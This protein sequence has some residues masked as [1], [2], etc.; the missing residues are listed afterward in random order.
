M[1]LDKSFSIGCFR[2][3]GLLATLLLLTAPLAHGQ[4]TDVAAE[5]SLVALWELNEAAGSG[6]VLDIN[7]TYTGTVSGGTTL[8]VPSAMTTLGTAAHF[9][10]SNGKIDIPYAA[11]LNPT[12]YTVEAWAQ[13]QGGAGSYRSP[14]T[15]RRSGPQ[16]QG[17][18]L[19]AASN[20]NWEYW[21]GTGTG[22]SSTPSGAPVITNQWV[23]LAATY[24]DGSG[25]KILYLNGHPV[26]TATA[27]LTP[28]TGLPTRIGAGG[29][30][31]S[32]AYWFNGTVDNVAILNQAM[33]HQNVANHYNAKSLYANQVAADGPAAYWRLGEQAGSSAYNAIDVTAHTG[34]YSNVAL[35]QTD[36]PIGN[37]I[38]TAASFAHG[39]ARVSVPYSAEL[40]P[41]GSFTV[42]AW[43]RADGGE[44]SY[45]SVLTSRS[46]AGNSQGFILYANNNNQWSFWNGAGTSADWH[47]IDGPQVALGEWVHLVGTYDAGT[48]VKSFYVDGVLAGSTSGVNYVA[49]TTNPLFIGM[50]GNGGT[51]FPFNGLIDEVAM[52]GQALTSAA[53]Q[54]HYLLASTGAE[55][56]RWDGGGTGMLWSTQDNWDPAGSP[57]DK[58]VVFDNTAAS[59]T[60]GTVTN[61]VDAN[62]T[63]ASILYENTGMHHTTAINSANTLTLEAASGEPRI[64]VAEAARIDGRLGSSQGIAKTGA[65]VLTLGGGGS[66]MGIGG[67]GVTVS[68]GTLRLNRSLGFDTGVFTPATAITVEAGGTLEVAQSWNLKH[69]NTVTV[70]GGTL[71]FTAGGAADSENYINN[72]ILT[73]ASVV[74]NG[75]RVGYFTDTLFTVTGNAG[76]TIS[77]PVVLVNDAGIREFTLDVA[78]GSAANDLIMSG[79]FS[80]YS[81]RAGTTIVKTGAGTLQLD[82]PLNHTGEM[83]VE[84]GMLVLNRNGS[85][86]AGNT[87]QFGSSGRTVTVN[88]GA[89][90]R[91]GGSWTMGDG[92]QH[93]LVANGGT[94][95][96]RGGEN[97]HNRITLTGGA[98]TTADSGRPWRTGHMGGDALITVNPSD[99]AST[100]SGLLYFVRSGSVEKTTF[101]VADGPAEYDL[102]VSA[103]IHDHPPASTYGGMVLAK[104]GPG[105]MVLSGANTFIGGVDVNAGT[106][107][108][109]NTSGSGTGTGTVTVHAGATLGGTGTIAG[110]VTGAGQVSPGTSTGILT[111]GSIDPSAGLGAV[112]EFGQTGGPVYEDAAD[113]VNDVLRVTGTTPVTG[114]LT[115]ANVIDVYFGLG[116]DI[117][118]VFRGGVYVDVAGDPQGLAEFYAAVENATYNYYVLDGGNYVGLSDYHPLFDVELST[119]ADPA[120]FGGDS[121]ILGG[122]M[123]FT[124]VPEPGTWMLLLATLACGLLVRRRRVG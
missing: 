98:V 21:A 2:R 23:H 87:G 28:N 14:V 16:Q 107:L 46:S 17:Y 117:D 71:S 10:G 124:I 89:T 55:M 30:E 114:P 112:F 38:D 69:S 66:P 41:T 93:H 120:S 63:V 121:P 32:G 67:S 75:I 5:S 39:S 12:S 22:W 68:E 45:R 13:V 70:D 47:R 43:A 49:N 116:V 106:L 86:A 113:S 101:D 36:T 20:N 118:D 103:A 97:Y 8:G 104:D 100:I 80:D 74:G 102:I 1:Q 11:P 57:A 34:T 51:D 77:N 108:V 110:Q 37:D 60:A 94:I 6:T 3:F 92:G 18:T 81:G 111:V 61:T 44:G 27:S 119:V 9:N 31:G 78:D 82:G 29:T 48:Q 64:F 122:V 96:F 53:V 4:F 115:P 58:I 25:A 33:A 90:L 88:S 42:E 7:S 56:I 50:G 85:L 76:T 54:R 26:S 40:N 91:V 35:R 84:G 105:T 79:T 62:T 59:G 72:L 123:Q 24:D 83:I 109:N 52:F 15:A 19:Y 73:D 95:D 99:V 65:G